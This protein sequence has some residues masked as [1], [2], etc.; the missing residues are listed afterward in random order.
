V[1]YQEDEVEP[2][3]NKALFGPLERGP[4]RLSITAGRLT[5][6]NVLSR[7]VRVLNELQILDTTSRGLRFSG[8]SVLNL[9]VGEH[10]HLRTALSL[11]DEAPRFLSTAGSLT[12]ERDWNGRWFW[13]VFAR[14]YR[15]NGRFEAA[16]PESNA[17][18]PL[19]SVQAG[20]G[21]RWQG[22]RTA[23]KVVAGPYLTRYRGDAAS[24]STF[25]H[26]YR[27]RDWLSVQ[28]AL[29]HRF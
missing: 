23:F 19:A 9:A 18:P 11:T 10:W 7:R 16:L 15:D 6:E 3:Y 25:G 4:S 5:F 17:A 20:V 12:V 28:L 24:E 22:E 21:V 14:G 13:S 1:I 26:L 29:S 8:Q 2:A 27:S